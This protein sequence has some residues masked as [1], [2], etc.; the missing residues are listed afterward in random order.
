MTEGLREQVVII[1][2]ARMMDAVTHHA[3]ISQRLSG[4]T[5]M[6]GVVGDQHN[7]GWFLDMLTIRHF[8]LMCF[9]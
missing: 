9:I 1:E 4:R 2:E 7:A 8:D 5:A 3:K 6:N